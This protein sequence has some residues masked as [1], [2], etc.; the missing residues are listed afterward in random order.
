M[1]MYW[2]DENEQVKPN[3]V[4]YDPVPDGAMR[5]FVGPGSFT[6][7][8]GVVYD[9]WSMTAQEIRDLLPTP[10]FDVWFE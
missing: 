3:V 5:R 2:D 1:L 8:Y 7:Q 6:E 9:F 10:E 4:S